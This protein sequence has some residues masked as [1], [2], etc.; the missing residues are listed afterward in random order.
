MGFP[1]L[2]AASAAHGEGEGGGREGGDFVGRM[3]SKSI[4]LQKASLYV[5]GNKTPLKPA[6]KSDSRG[7]GG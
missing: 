5:A 7:V 4:S 3:E 2:F 1:G 6:W